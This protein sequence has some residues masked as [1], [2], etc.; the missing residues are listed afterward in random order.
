M[1]TLLQI[2]E[3]TNEP[4]IIE[5][6]FMKKE[7]RGGKRPGSGQLNKLTHMLTG[8][9]M[10]IKRINGDIVTCYLSYPYSLLKFRLLIEV[11]ICHRDNLIFEN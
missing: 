11:A 6:L 7:T 10:S 1:K 3:L 8:E 9:P 4:N 5:D 2:F